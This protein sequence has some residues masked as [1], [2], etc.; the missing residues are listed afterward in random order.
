MQGGGL[1]AAA[2]AR[3]KMRRCSSL[4]WNPEVAT[5][6]LVA[7][8]DDL[9][10][11]LQM[12]DLRNSVAPLRELNGHDKARPAAAG[13]VPTEQ[14]IPHW[15]PL[16]PNAAVS[17]PSQHPAAASARRP[18]SVQPSLDSS[19][20]RLTNRPRRGGALLVSQRRA[21]RPLPGRARGA[22]ARRAPAQGVYGVAWSAADPALLLSTGKDGRTLLWDA[23]DERGDPL[24]ELRAPGGWAF[25]VLWAPA[26]PGVFALSSFGGSGQGGKARPSGRRGLHRDRGQAGLRCRRA[27]AAA[28][29]GA[30]RARER[31]CTVTCGACQGLPR[32][33]FCYMGRPGGAGRPAPPAAEAAGR[34]A[35]VRGPRRCRCTA[36]RPSRPRA[37]RRPSTPTSPR[38]PW[39]QVT[40]AAP[41]P[42]RPALQAPPGPADARP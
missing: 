26:H 21:A 11:T 42:T 14:G 28:R 30:A 6:L 4:A 22:H 12:W 17:A 3:R 2:R 18:C 16:R 13:F 27:A 9:S 40:R 24:G 8:E 39:P 32:G 33:A 29:Q 35:R 36:W 19:L 5:Q 1:T 7:C 38:A 41:R 31:S 20:D 10:P 23:A 15:E 25:D 37:P 34:R